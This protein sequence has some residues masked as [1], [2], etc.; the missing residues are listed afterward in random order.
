MFFPYQKSYGDGSSK[1]WA[2]PPEGY[3]YGGEL[4]AQVCS[5]GPLVSQHP[6][7]S[8]T[9]TRWILLSVLYRTPCRKAGIP[10]AG[11]KIGEPPLGHPAI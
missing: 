6:R 3:L 11:A 1:E 9:P 2:P 5:D 7:R 4:Y 8:S 10:E